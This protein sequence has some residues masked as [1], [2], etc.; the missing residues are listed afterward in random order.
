MTECWTPQTDSSTWFQAANF[1]IGPLQNWANG[2]MAW[3]LAANS[4]NGP[5]L[6]TGGCATCPG[7]VRINDDGT[8]TFNMA[9]YLMAQF[10]KF[11][12][13][14]AKILSGKGYSSTS[15]QPGLQMVA[16]LNPDGTRSVVMMNT[17]TSAVSV[18]LST[19]SGQV[20]SGNVPMSSV[21]TWVLPPVG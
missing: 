17:L 15:Y 16:S 21:V 19:A 9:Y 10:S 4:T 12:P 2:V 14:G 1:T 13:K 5:Y 20:W 6:S 11:I 3:T 8:Y 7:L 18:R